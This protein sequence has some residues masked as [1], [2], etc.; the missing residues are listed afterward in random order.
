MPDFV[1]SPEG[2]SALR[3]KTIKKQP[4]SSTLAIFDEAKMAKENTKL[5]RL[6]KNIPFGQKGISSQSSFNVFHGLFSEGN[7]FVINFL[8]QLNGGMKTFPSHGSG[9][10][11]HGVDIDE[12]SAIPV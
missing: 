12:F 5:S 8:V 10:L 11:Q 7:P 3:V 4:A 2:L 9:P 1:K 6:N